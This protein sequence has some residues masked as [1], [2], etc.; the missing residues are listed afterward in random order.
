MDRVRA[1]HLVQRTLDAITAD[2][3]ELEAAL[4][5]GTLDFPEGR[6]AALVADAGAHTWTDAQRSRGADLLGRSHLLA[7][8]LA[9][10]MRET[11]HA[12]RLLGDAPSQPRYLDTIV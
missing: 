5:S 6:A 7:A 10:R 11:T 9:G 3:D 8:A 2:L 4:A 1:A 12:R